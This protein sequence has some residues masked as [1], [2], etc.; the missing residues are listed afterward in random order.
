MGLVKAY[1]DDLT[2]AIMNHCGINDDEDGKNHDRIFKWVMK[3]DFG[4]K[5]EAQIIELYKGERL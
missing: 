2:Y 4:H 5:S 3:Q 1:L